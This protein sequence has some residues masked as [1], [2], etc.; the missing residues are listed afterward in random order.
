M[1]SQNAEIIVDI[2]K[3]GIKD[4]SEKLGVELEY[5]LTYENNSQVK[6]EDEF[7][8]KWL[9]NALRDEYEDDIL[10]EEDH[11]IGVAGKRDTLTLEPAGQFELSAGP[12]VDVADAY[13]CFEHLINRIN[14]LVNPHGIVLNALGYHPKCMAEDL[15]IIPKVRYQLMNEYFM[16]FSPLGIRMMRATGS[17]QV[18]IDYHSVDDC[19]NKLRLA[20]CCSP[21]FALLCDNTA[22]FEGRPR[23][24][25]LM[26]TEVWEDCDKSRC[27]IVPGVLS[28]DFTIEDYAEYVLNAPQMFET[29]QGKQVVSGRKL[30]EIYAD[31][32]MTEAEAVAGMSQLFNDV[33]LKNFIEIRPADA[34]PLPYA[35]AYVALIK[36]LFYG[37]DS[38]NKLQ[39]LFI[40]VDKDEQYESA[41]QELMKSGYDAEIFGNSA[42]YFAD[43]LIEITK[44]GLIGEDVKYLS[45]F[46][47]L[48]A[49]R[50]TLA[51]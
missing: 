30:K 42:K 25:R 7:G 31:K 4:K 18:S 34:L 35:M 33:R 10:D 8:Q 48:V 41:K 47:K 43:K 50:K 23:T 28:S 14:E 5:T 51:D 36:G 22:I 39:E 13:A 24:H 40:D 2:V 11:L 37:K 27:G 20:F 12:F 29:V 21:I 46:E 3:S 26:R 49:D 45:P 15:K 19:L 6:Y 17:T 44:A 1:L 9:M 38:L 32:T 16:K